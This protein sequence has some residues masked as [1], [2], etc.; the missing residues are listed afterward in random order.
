MGEDTSGPCVLTALRSPFLPFSSFLPLFS[1]FSPFLLWLPATG[2]G[3]QDGPRS[4]RAREPRVAA[5]Y[6]NG[7]ASGRAARAMG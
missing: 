6:A 3:I 5:G 1:L 2:R 7:A 4:P